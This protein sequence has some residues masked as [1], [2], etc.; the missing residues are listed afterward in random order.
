MTRPRKL[1]IQIPCYNEAETLPVTLRAI[2]AQIPEIDVVEVMVIND[3]S[4]D[5]T[6]EA[7]RNGNV[8]HILDFQNNQGLAKTFIKGIRE[9]ARLGADYVVNLDADNQY[10]AEGIPK[11]LQPLLRG[12][13]DMVVGERPIGEIRHFSWLKKKLQLLGSWMVRKL[14]GTSVRDTTSGFRALNRAA[15]LRLTIFNP[16]TYTHESLIAANDLDLRV[17]GVSIRVNDLVL[18]KSRLMRSIP[19]YIFKS[20]TT[21]IRFYILY[22]PYVLFFRLG[23]LLLLIGA[24]LMIFCMLEQTPL[25]RGFFETVVGAAVLMFT[26]LLAFIAAFLSDSL[27]VNRKLVEELLY[28]QRAILSGKEEDS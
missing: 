21:I 17:T 8:D 24:G 2:P 11:L 19:E 13:A 5:S 26:G 20:A 7:A 14:S 27:R 1:I 12:E 22:N 10:N 4:T 25:T 16:Y 18:R 28:R 23:L 15:M 6:V 3:G 9:A